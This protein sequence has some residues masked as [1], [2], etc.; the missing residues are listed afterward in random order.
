[1]SHT[2][3][4]IDFYFLQTLPLGYSALSVAEVIVPQIICVALT[5]TG[6]SFFLSV[7]KQV[8]RLLSSPLT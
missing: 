7:K 2:L 5:E 6:L 1:M 8:G 3:C 4:F